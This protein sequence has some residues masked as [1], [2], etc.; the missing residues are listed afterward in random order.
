MT[1]E[2]VAGLLAGEELPALAAP[3]TPARFARERGDRVTVVVNGRPAE[4]ADG[5]TVADLLARAR[6][7][8]GRAGVAVAVDAEVVPRGQWR[9]RPVPEGARV[10]VLTAIQGG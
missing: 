3:F 10:E 6:P 9:T 2:L 4:V 1:G 7:A 8:G 5:A